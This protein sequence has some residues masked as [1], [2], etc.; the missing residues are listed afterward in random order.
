[1][2]VLEDFLRRFDRRVSIRIRFFFG[3]STFLRS[4]LESSS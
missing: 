4:S 3:G 1:M 2:A